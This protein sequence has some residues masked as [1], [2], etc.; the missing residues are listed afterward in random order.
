MLFS[1]V[2][3]HGLVDPFPIEKLIKLDF[4]DAD[5]FRDKIVERAFIETT[6]ISLLK[7]DRHTIVSGPIGAGKS[8]IFKLLKQQSNLF[9]DYIDNRI[10]VPIEESISFHVLRELTNEYFPKN[11]PQL[12]YQV[13]WFFHIAVRISESV[14]KLHSFPIDENEKEINKF[15][16]QIDS[17][18][19]N[20]GILDKVKWIF[21][22]LSAKLEAK[23]SSTPL[24]LQASV[25]AKQK[26]GKKKVNLNKIIDHCVK[27]VKN[28]KLPGFLVLID[29]VDKF[30]AGEEY[31]TQR[32]YIESLFE[33]EDDL[34]SLDNI[35][36]NIFIRSDL[37]SR[38]N[39]SSL[40]YDKVSDRTVKLEWTDDEILEFVA[41]RILISLES[42]NIASLSDI[43]RSTDL[44]QC[45]DLPIHDSFFLKL[46][47]SFMKRIIIEKQD[48]ANSKRTDLITALSKAI[49]TKVFPRKIPHCNENGEY[50]DVLTCHF[51]K[52]HFR[53]G[54]DFTTPR[55][56]LIFLKKVQ[57]QV[58]SYY[59][60]NPHLTVNVVKF[61]DDCEWKLFERSS[62]YKAYVESKTLYIKNLC[63]IDS[64]WTKWIVQLLAIKNDKKD[65]NYKWIKSHVVSA[66]DDAAIAFIA[67]L[68]SI[69]F[70]HIK[71]HDPDIKKR[72]YK[73]PIMYSTTPTPTH[74]PVTE[75]SV[76]GVI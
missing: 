74:S 47:P 14:S 32:K 39:F 22:D 57:K 70:F 59:D 75:S 6:S 69:G 24:T 72:I 25:D 60:D 55:Y 28:R 53:D 62:V 76:D 10:V 52:T 17:H 4:G 46:L 34:A 31:D 63:N 8:A 73:L 61:G 51:I 58:A 48:I 54:R 64:K 68:Q 7:Q 19:Q 5:G 50:E 27:A 42:S 11:D 30:V 21:Q 41:K 43:M 20:Q 35:H 16:Q 36:F 2:P 13:I 45:K 15:L 44:S 3:K 33:V 12:I 40:G 29:K 66:N 71:K 18:G 26:Q 9:K 67:F 1:K 38:L 49:I 65:F 56:L 37:F 23:I